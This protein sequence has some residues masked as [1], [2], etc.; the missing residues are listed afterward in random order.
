L[1]ENGSLREGG[2]SQTTDSSSEEGLFNCV[3]DTTARRVTVSFGRNVS[4]AD[5]ARYVKTIKEDP[6]FESTFAEIVDLTAAEQIDLQVK[7]FLNL[8][9]YVDP[10][11]R[12][13]KRA[14]VIRTP[15]QE[16]AAR[17]HKILRGEQNIEI[18]SS[19]GEAEEW[20]SS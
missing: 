18:F 17:L 6:D 7:E 10:F 1:L 13:A 3:V 5:V 16:H 4:V 12:H 20:V 11:S 2:V 9:D 8:A 15:M 19:F 14:F